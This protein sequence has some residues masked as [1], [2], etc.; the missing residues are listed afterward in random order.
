MVLRLLPNAPPQKRGGNLEKTNDK[1]H[2][3]QRRAK[4]LGF[5]KTA[6][7]AVNSSSDGRIMTEN[8]LWNWNGQLAMV[9]SLTDQVLAEAE[10]VIQNVKLISGQ[11][12]RKFRALSNVAA[13]IQTPRAGESQ[14]EH[15]T[16]VR[17][18]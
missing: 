3:T 11:K 16:E 13:S 8:K 4:A 14:P 12:G 9:S 5:N 2:R 7:Q 15:Q 17:V 10:S 18:V 6:S 1:L